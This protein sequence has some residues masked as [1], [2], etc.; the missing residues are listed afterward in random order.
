MAK[1]MACAM[2]LPDL[3]AVITLLERALDFVTVANIMCQVALMEK[4]V[5][6]KES[7]SGF[8]R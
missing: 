4:S 7:L 3:T 6:Q 5:I 2:V 1:A 8:D